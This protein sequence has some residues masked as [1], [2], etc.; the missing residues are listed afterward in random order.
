MR[1][2]DLA[3]KLVQS[4]DPILLERSE[5][6][7]ND[8]H[9]LWMVR[10]LFPKMCRTLIEYQGMGLAAP[11]IG[12]NIRFFIMQFPNELTYGCINPKILEMSDETF[13][14]EEGCL[15]FPGEFI[16]T[17]RANKIRVSFMN[18]DGNQVEWELEGIYSICFQHETD[19]LDGI[20]FHKRIENNEI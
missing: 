17:N 5:P 10:T 20:V 13:P 9:D 15:S 2:Y 1:N 7:K 18:L 3:L 8:F 6:L 11:Q 19:H 14:V 4:D 12:L 16:K